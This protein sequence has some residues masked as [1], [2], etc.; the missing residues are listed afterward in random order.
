MLPKEIINIIL[1]EYLNDIDVNISFGIFNKIKLD[2][3]EK[4]ENILK[5]QTFYVR[6]LFFGEEY[7]YRFISI[8]TLKFY[9]LT[10]VILESSEKNKIL[11]E[12]APEAYPFE[13]YTVSTIMY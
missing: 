12:I 5:Y 11:T 13:F 7:I 1:F 6:E 10:L 2:N 9:R 4:I 8:N 3:F